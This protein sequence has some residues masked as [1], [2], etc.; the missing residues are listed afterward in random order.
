MES[1]PTKGSLGG[2]G[3]RRGEDWAFLFGDVRHLS[4][5]FRYEVEY[6]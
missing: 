6:E 2:T 4:G 3:W 1:F 5:D